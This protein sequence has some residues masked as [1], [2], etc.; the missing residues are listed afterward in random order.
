MIL[1]AQT[2]KMK[3]YTDMFK[4]TGNK[5]YKK[6]KLIRTDGIYVP[7]G[8]N[9][10]LIVAKLSKNKAAF[11]IFGYSFLTE[12]ENKVQ[13][14][15]IDG[16]YPTA[17]TISSGKYPISRSLFFYIKNSHSKNA[18]SLD[19]YVKMFMSEN[20]IGPDGILSEIGLISLSK[21]TRKSTRNAVLNKTK[22]TLEALNTK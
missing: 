6:Y 21:N 2:K 12:N 18:P 9:D 22:L 14:T 19:K 7:S 5:T 8:E 4:K 20:M 15:K 11:G 16:V 10:N 3:V 13:G 1:K 17:A